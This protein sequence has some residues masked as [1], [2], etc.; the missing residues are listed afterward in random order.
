M[1]FRQ[2]RQTVPSNPEFSVP[3]VK[4]LL[5]QIEALLERKIPPEEWNSL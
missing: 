5:R 3:Q 1:I 2:R 4:M